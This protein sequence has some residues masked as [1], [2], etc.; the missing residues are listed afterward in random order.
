MGSTELALLVY[1]LKYLIRWI[2]SNEK[3]KEAKRRLKKK[4]QW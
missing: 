4:G 2:F 1:F 3:N